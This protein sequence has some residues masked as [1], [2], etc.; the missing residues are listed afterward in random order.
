MLLP[1]PGR[2]GVDRKR[3]GSKQRKLVSND[4]PTSKRKAGEF[5]L[6]PSGKLPAGRRDIRPPAVTKGGGEA[7]GKKDFLKL[8]DGII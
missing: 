6:N 5:R 1:G 4:G 3:I 7:C 8:P 2:A